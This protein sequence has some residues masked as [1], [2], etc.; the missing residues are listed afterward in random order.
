MSVELC[1]V[2]TADGLRLD[3]ALENPPAGTDA[4]GLTVAAFLLVHGTASHF[5]A[6]GLLE[7][8]ARQ[9]VA[10]GVAVLRINTRGHDAMTSIPGRRGSVR[11][12][13]AY[14]TIADC[15]HDLR[16]WLDFLTGRGITRVALVGHSMGGVK[17]IYAQ[18]HNPHPA[19]RCVVGLSPPRFCHAHF[20]SHSQGDA[21]R[22][23][24]RRAEQTVAEGRPDE[25]LSVRQPLPLVLTAAGFLAKYGPHDDYDLL[26]HLP[27]ITCPTLIVLGTGSVATS[28]AFDTLPDALRTLQPNHTQIT[29]ELVDGADTIYRGCEQIPFERTAAWL[30]SLPRSASP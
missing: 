21:F 11:G 15:R 10:A 29:L 1:R 30:R 24:Y 12:G 14:E 7:T 9:A 17:A 6:P 8:F 5:Y 18:A 25:L 28:P 16:A 3:G 2:E 26:H 27:R 13:A 22:A 19:V 20:M 23:D 4:A